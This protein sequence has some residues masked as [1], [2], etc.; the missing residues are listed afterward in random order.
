MFCYFQLFCEFILHK[1]FHC[2]SG[3]PGCLLPELPPL[4]CSLN[5]GDTDGILAEDTCCKLLFCV[6]ENVVF[7]VVFFKKTPLPL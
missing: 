3:Y 2:H 7:V 1:N 6:Q 4:C 5:A